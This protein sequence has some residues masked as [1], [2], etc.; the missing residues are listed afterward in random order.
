MRV[1][2]LRRPHRLERL[3]EVPR[4]HDLHAPGLHRLRRPGVHSR[5]VRDGTAGRILHRH[6]LHPGEELGEP[7]LELVAAAVDDLPPRQQVEVVAFDGVHEGAR[8]ALPGD[9]V[10]PAACREVGAAVH[11]RQAGGNRV[12]AVKIVQQP[13]IERPSAQGT[14]NGW[15]IER[16][17]VQ[18]YRV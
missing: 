7:R 1:E 11:A 4:R 2:L 3:H 9:Q 6:A 12:G 8:F 18:K 5:D 13:S 16:H 10:I 17:G 14:L 15:N